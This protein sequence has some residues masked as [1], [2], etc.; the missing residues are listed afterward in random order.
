MIPGALVVTH[1]DLGEVM[2]REACRLIGQEQRIVAMSTE[3]LS[4]SEISDRVKEQIGTEPW[5]VFT[6][7]PGTSPT[8]RACAAISS[9]QAVVTGINL[10]ML[11]SFL[12][13]RKRLAIPELAAK[14]VEDGKR[15]LELIW[16]RP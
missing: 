9:G 8:V 6:D 1:G 13:H 7:A 11:I 12:I 16:P 14:M 15:S 2:V 10:G 5:I 3:G 4:A